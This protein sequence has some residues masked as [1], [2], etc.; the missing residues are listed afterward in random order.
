M[1]RQRRARLRSAFAIGLGVAAL[2]TQTGCIPYSG[3]Q[4]RETAIPAVQTG[5]TSIVVGLI[6]GVFAAVD[7]ESQTGG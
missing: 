1:N 3:T 6:D 5:V 4:F 2:S 7:V